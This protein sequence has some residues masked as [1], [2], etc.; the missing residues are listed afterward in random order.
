MADEPFPIVL[1][2]TARTGHL[3]QGGMIPVDAVPPALDTEC[4]ACA[5]PL[6]AAEGKVGAAPDIYAGAPYGLY[7]DPPCP[8][9]AASAPRRATPGAGT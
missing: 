9:R 1:A 3:T 2:L 5:N 8:S 4:Y 6:T 7:C